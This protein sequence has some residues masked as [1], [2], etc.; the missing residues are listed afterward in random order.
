[1][2][3]TFPTYEP[4]ER[5]KVYELIAENLLAQIAGRRLK[6]GDALPPER[7]LTQRYQAGRSSVREALR[8]LESKGLIESVGNG[9]FAVANF[10]KD[11]KSVV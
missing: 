8:M 4:I 2:A 3:E 11:R 9:S 5:Q 6:P 1:M 7:E 10:R